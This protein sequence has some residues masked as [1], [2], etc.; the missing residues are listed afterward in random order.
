M[1]SLSSQKGFTLVEL[2]IVLMIIGLLIGGILKGQE[3]IENARSLSLMRQ[4]KSYEAANMTFRSSYGALA[5]DMTNP[6]TRIPNCTTSPCN[7]PGT[8]NGRL[9]AYPEPMNF[10]LHLAKANMISG[11][12][13]SGTDVYTLLPK[14]PYGGSAII[15]HNGLNTHIMNLYS[16]L[17]SDLPLL[18]ARQSS[19]IDRKM[20]DGNPAT[21]DIYNNDIITPSCVATGEYTISGN[22]L[23]TILIEYDL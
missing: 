2:A 10:W 9:D 19:Q 5:G 1:R 7:M 20:D 21:G 22:A 4:L 16:D 11:I 12:D 14:T 18:N 3:L 23:C 15:G 17:D 8:G 13:T 6:G